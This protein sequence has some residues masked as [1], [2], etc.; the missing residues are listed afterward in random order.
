MYTE[1]IVNSDREHCRIF[2]IYSLWAGFKK[3]D[4][5][6]EVEKVLT[7]WESIMD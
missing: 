4:C 7:A 3:I 1:E 2:L 6:R 5:D